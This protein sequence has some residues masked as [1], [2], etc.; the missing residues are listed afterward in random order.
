MFKDL[1]SHKKTHMSLVETGHFMTRAVRS[2]KEVSHQTKC[3]AP[4]P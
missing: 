3:L 1:E 2:T 4:G